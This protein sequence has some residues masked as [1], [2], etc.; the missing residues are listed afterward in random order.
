MSDQPAHSDPKEAT[1]AKLCAYLEGELSP[2]DRTEIEQHLAA[3]P[4]HRKLLADLAKT[5]EWMRSIPPETAPSDLAEGFQGQVERNMLLDDPGDIGSGMSNRWPQYAMLAAIIVLVLGLGVTLVIILKG[6]TQKPVAMSGPPAAT[7]PTATALADQDAVKSDR[8]LAVA[9][10]ATIP[11]PMVAAAMPAP[12]SPIP[13][14]VGGAV[15]P[16]TDKAVSTP[17]PGVPNADDI[18]TRLAASGYRIPSDSRTICFVV[19]SDTPETTVDQVHV[20]FIHHQ[21]LVEAPAGLG[22]NSQQSDPKT[23]APTD[24]PVPVR[25]AGPAN[26]NTANNSTAETGQ[27]QNSI[28]GGTTSTNAGTPAE[29]LCVAHGLS[30]LQLAL[31]NASLAENNPSHPVNQFTLSEGNPTPAPVWTPPNSIFKGQTLTVII[32][33]LV[34]PGIDK[35]N[36][37]K[38]ADDGSISLPM[39]DPL[40]AVG[41]TAGELEQRIAA[42]YHEANL[43]PSATVTVSAAAATQPATMPS[44]NPTAAALPTTRPADQV[45]A[46]TQPARDQGVDVVVIIEKTAGK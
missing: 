16:L 8:S 11:A 36:V 12:A 27:Q 37:V 17:P 21:L 46:A 23:A 25:V 45:T 6:P 9:Q 44:T 32:P 15:N 3:N 13:S 14:A 10:P 34:G 30:P 40:Q 4:Q 26:A 38:V 7:K 33:Q 2:T 31:L 22:A 35:T 41:I 18:K 43:I 24:T 29:T 1:E 19:R 5:R 42:K 28:Q 20:F 39:I